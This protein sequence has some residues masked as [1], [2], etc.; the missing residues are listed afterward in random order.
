MDEK[1]KQTMIFLKCKLDVSK[2]MKIKIEE[3]QED[4]NS[5]S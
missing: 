4:V 3:L 1:A 2:A 5:F